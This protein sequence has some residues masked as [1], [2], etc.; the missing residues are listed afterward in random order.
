MLSLLKSGVKYGGT[1]PGCYY[2][3]VYLQMAILIPLMRPILVKLG[4][5]NSL[6]F[7]AI[8]SLGCEIICSII[9][10][11]EFVYRL[12]AIRYIFLLWFG[13][14]WVKDGIQFNT[15][16]IMASLL[17]LF[18]TIYFGYSNEDLEPWFFNTG[19]TTHRWICYFWL[20][21]FVGILYKV[22][23]WIFDSSIVQKSVKLLA[24]ASYE[25]FLIQMAYYALIMPSHFGFLNNQYYQYGIFL[26]MAFMVSIPFGTCL[27]RLEKNIYE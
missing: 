21:I 22:Y 11:P 12:L 17:G 24:S 6:L 13:W 27:Y 7:I 19:W 5:W 20:T 8:L 2:P 14:I 4:K 9:K 3:W 18:A 15:T 16:A 1:G 23:L 25:I 10:M 26:G